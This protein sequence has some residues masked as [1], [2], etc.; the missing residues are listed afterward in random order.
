[1]KWEE[2]VAQLTV[3]GESAL[4][5]SL[6]KL[7]DGGVN[8]KAAYTALATGMTIALCKF[9]IRHSRRITL[10]LFTETLDEVLENAPSDP[11][12]DVRQ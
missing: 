4:D 6:N 9:Q 2:L 10:E 12:P 1:M 5:E 3:A 11:V 8:P 7:A